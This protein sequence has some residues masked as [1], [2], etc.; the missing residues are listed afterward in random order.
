G[1][2]VVA[3]QKCSTQAIWEQSNCRE[4]AKD[5]F[6]REVARASVVQTREH[7]CATRSCTERVVPR[8][9]VKDAIAPRAASA[10]RRI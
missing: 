7:N 10:R 4:Q 8:I 2:L 5:V 1:Q 3:L 9:L 6:R